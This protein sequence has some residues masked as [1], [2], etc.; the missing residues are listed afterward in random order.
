MRSSNSFTK[1]KGIELIAIATFQRD[2]ACCPRRR[3]LV[4]NRRV[5]PQQLLRDQGKS[6]GGTNDTLLI[7]RRLQEL[8]RQRKIPLYMLLH[9]SAESVR[10]CRPRAA[11]GGTRTLWRTNQDAENYPR[12]FHDGVRGLARVLM[13][14]ST[15]NGLVPRRGLRQGCVV[16]PLRGGNVC[17]ART[18]N[19]CN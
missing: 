1:K 6:R 2:C 17:A 8:G 10:L 13:T 16:S 19:S 15:R 12:S 4:E 14:A 7:V 5:P 3:S 9:R 11:V 18:A